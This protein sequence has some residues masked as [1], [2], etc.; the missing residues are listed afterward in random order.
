MDGGFRRI[1]PAWISSKELGVLWV[2]LVKEIEGR[3]ESKRQ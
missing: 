1:H 2:M 3:P